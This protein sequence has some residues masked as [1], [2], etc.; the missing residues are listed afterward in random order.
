MP[1]P[2]RADQ[3][4]QT[5]PSVR[6]DRLVSLT[7]AVKLSTL[8][9]DSWLRHHKAKLVPLSPGRWGVRL[10]DALMLGD[11]APNP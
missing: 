8:S 7:E 9:R 11:D 10:R 1:S 3:V 6:L 4:F 2:R 5:D